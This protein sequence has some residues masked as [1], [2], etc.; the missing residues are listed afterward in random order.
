M[1]TN[2]FYWQGFEII[3]SRQFLQCFDSIVHVGPDTMW[4]P[5][6]NFVTKDCDKNTD[7]IFR[8]GLKNVQSIYL[9]PKSS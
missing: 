4:K 5:G 8:A 9:L 6:E 1:K 2:V 3:K 7:S